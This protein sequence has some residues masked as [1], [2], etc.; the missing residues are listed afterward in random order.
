MMYINIHHTSQQHFLLIA[1]K[2]NF[3]RSPIFDAENPFLLLRIVALLQFSWLL[4]FGTLMSVQKRT[5]PTPQTFTISFLQ[6]SSA[7]FT[8]A[9]AQSFHQLHPRVF[10]LPPPHRELGFRRAGLGPASLHLRRDA[11]Q[12]FAQP[13]AAGG[14]AGATRGLRQGREGR[15]RLQ[16]PWP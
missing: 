5:F 2:P 13:D 16:G 11:A 4:L 1:R 14:A 3:V 7:Q 9:M 10:Q 15:L 12:G 8:T 6:K